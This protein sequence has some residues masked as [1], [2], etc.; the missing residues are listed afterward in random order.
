MQVKGPL[1]FGLESKVNKWSCLWLNCGKL[2]GQIQIRL[3]ES[4]SNSIGH[5]CKGLVDYWHKEIIQNSI[6]HLKYFGKIWEATNKQKL[7]C[8]QCNLRNKGQRSTAAVN[9]SAD[10]CSVIHCGSLRPLQRGQTSGS[11]AQQPLTI[12][13][14]DRCVGFNGT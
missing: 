8:S 6:K 11:T 2:H 5:I 4:L 12:Q 10:L 7:F 13:L 9:M 1:Y 14:K 3:F